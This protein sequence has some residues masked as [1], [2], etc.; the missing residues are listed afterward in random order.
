[1][2]SHLPR[3]RLW[4]R[5]GLDPRA[6]LLDGALVEISVGKFSRVDVCRDPPP[7]LAE[8]CVWPKG[9][10]TPGLLNAHAHLDYSWLRG[11][12]PRGNRF[13]EWVGAIVKARRALIAESMQA[14]REACAS[15]IEEA[16]GNGTTEIWDI[17]S[18]DIARP[19]LESSGL[20]AISFA[21]IV[22]PTRA[23]WEADGRERLRQ[24]KLASYISRPG[25]MCAVGV[26]P[27]ATYTVIPEALEAC[28]H[29]ANRRA[30]PL[31]VHLAESAE[32][33]RLLIEGTG[34]LFEVMRTLGTEN[35]RDEIGV[36]VSPIERARR[37]GALQPNCL[38]V[39]CNLP[40]PGEA[41]LLA[42]SE[43]AV[44]FCPL[45][46]A[47][48]DLPKYPLHE[49]RDAGVRLALGTDSLAS[50]RQLDVR[51]E[52]AETYRKYKIGDSLWLLG[53]ATGAELGIQA[54]YGGRGLLSVGRP[55]QWAVWELGS[56]PRRPT[57]E[58]MVES[59]LDDG[60]RCVG[61]SA[62]N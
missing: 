31:A 56:L 27:H 9:L 51:L 22:A 20:S 45:S 17:G 41:A 29:W 2:R 30:A 32:E 21:E 28:S 42:R 58:M 43:V 61:S 26:S 55:A 34:E 23:A 8:D 49:Y 33:N 5:W 11:S 3:K 37:A 1:M 36:G 57:A 12:M 35:V 16:A 54:P 48:F 39:H 24:S 44:A 59:W 10:L 15:A 53:L 7:D 13:A 40:Q 6:G 14:V 19:M 4:A 38:A 46:H 18:L 62:L 60:T 52:A 25:S 47:W 50:N